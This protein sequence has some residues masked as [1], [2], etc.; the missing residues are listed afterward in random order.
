LEDEN[1]NPFYIDIRPFSFLFVKEGEWLYLRGIKQINLDKQIVFSET[2]RF[3][4]LPPFFSEDY[5]YQ[6]NYKAIYRKTNKLAHQK[7]ESSSLTQITF[8]ENKISTVKQLFELQGIFILNQTNIR[9]LQKRTKF[10]S[11]ITT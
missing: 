3:I 8:S 1:K 11:K 9:P 4:A 7:K 10:C 6:A 2:G 5:E